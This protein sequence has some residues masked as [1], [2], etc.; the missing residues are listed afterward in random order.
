MK[1]IRILT[2][3][4]IVSCNQINAE[5]FSPTDQEKSLSAIQ[6]QVR[7]LQID[8]QKMLDKIKNSF[9]SKKVSITKID[10]TKTIQSIEQT[11]KQ[12]T[13][14]ANRI[15][16]SSTKNKT[17]VMKLHQL[18]ENVFKL[19]NETN[20][21]TELQESVSLLMA[22]LQNQQ[23]PQQ[24]MLDYLQTNFNGTGLDVQKNIY[25]QLGL[26][27]LPT[28]EQVLREFAKI[29]EDPKQSEQTKFRWRQ[30]QYL[31]RQPIG[32]MMYDLWLQDA[33]AFNAVVSKLPKQEL[34]QLYQYMNMAYRQKVYELTE[35][36]Q[37]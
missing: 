13:D 36:L 24:S 30:M 25:V 8:V 34:I 9:N 23:N 29:T 26:A 21:M 5:N 12:I 7:N 35:Q 1:I 27:P 19:G 33:S 14:V 15:Q 6:A 10:I 22:P 16:Q 28:Q 37:N 4:S 18:M 17:V 20:I 32:K 3:I 2:L 11:L 31:M